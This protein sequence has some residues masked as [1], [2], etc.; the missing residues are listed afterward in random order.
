ML[1][2]W[3]LLMAA[4][5]PP[6]P[7]SPTAAAPPS[8]IPPTAAPTAP[9][10]T[11]EAATTPPQVILTHSVMSS[12]G[13]TLEIPRVTHGARCIRLNVALHGIHLPSGA[14]PD[15]TPLM[16]IVDPAIFY[17]GSELAL[18]P[19]GGGGGGGQRD[20]GSFDLGQEI[21]YELGAPIPADAPLPMIV[22]L[23]LNEALGFGSPLRFAVR[24]EADGSPHCGLQGSTAP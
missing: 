21:V 10:A 18:E 9:P 19:R 14:A 16:P 12:T 13:A 1:A 15:S 7:P 20:D 8:S 3:L 22:E 24:A 17:G 23:T 6:L 5:S 11:A 4:C 2:G